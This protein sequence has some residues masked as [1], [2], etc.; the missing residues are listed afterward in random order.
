VI[1]ERRIRLLGAY[2]MQIEATGA[3]DVG[4]K[5]PGNEDSFLIDESIGLYV[6][7]DGMGGHA[8]G[9]VASQRSIEFVADYIRGR[10]HVI[11]RAHDA[12]GGYY[13]VVEMVESAI[14]FASA[15]LYE[16][17]CS[18][19]DCRGMGTT[20]T[21]LLVVDAKAI[22][23]H[24]GDSRLYVVRG[25]EVHQLSTDH[26]LGNEV[27]ATGGLSEDSIK[28][29]HYDHIL[30]RVIGSQKSLQV[31]T[32]LFD[33]FDKD[34]CLLCSDGLS[35]YFGDTDQLKSQIASSDVHATVD[36]FIDFANQQGG[37][38]N[39]TVVALSARSSSNSSAKADSV[40]RRMTALKKSF[41]GQ[42]MSESRV[43]RLLNVSS[44]VS[45]SSGQT[46]VIAG[47]RDTGLY[48]VL[49]GSVSL[50]RPDGHCTELGQ[51]DCFGQTSLAGAGRSPVTATVRED[52]ELLYLS[53]KRFDK[54][55]SRIP[56][57]GRQLFKNLADELCRTCS[58]G[59]SDSSDWLG[60][61]VDFPSDGPG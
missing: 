52:A 23:G 15:R 49:Q 61:T 54:L 11:E 30:T 9:E 36:S 47:Q 12:P 44:V 50:E 17:A 5:R 33:L 31:E 46:I 38:D 45:I 22:M 53:R 21:L 2:F 43:I 28:A 42:G 60:D 59:S 57:L 7:C 48:I 24:V 39:I 58:L 8:A 14:Q 4:R 29:S 34:I 3:T 35:N 55:A 16:L 26:T 41:L 40:Q 56:K 6:V 20:M 10:K 37:A 32:L 1:R 18:D 25:D 19:S 51:S 13:R 27:R